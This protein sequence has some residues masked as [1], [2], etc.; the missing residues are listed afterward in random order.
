GWGV[1][2][3]KPRHMLRHGGEYVVSVAFRPDGK[4]LA[5]GGQATVRLWDVETGRQEKELAGH[6][7]DVHGLAYSPDGKW[8]AS[9]GQDRAVRL[10]DV[11][12][13]RPGQRFDELPTRGTGVA[14][15][16]DG[17][18]LSF[19]AGDAGDPNGYL[20]VW[21]I[22]EGK[23]VVSKDG[24]TASWVTFAPDSQSVWAGPWGTN[25]NAVL[26]RFDLAG[27]EL[28]R[29]AYPELAGFASFALTAD[30]TTL[31]VADQAKG[32]AA[33]D[34]VTGR[35]KGPPAPPA[36]SPDRPPKDAFPGELLV[37]ETFDD[38]KACPL[39][40]GTHDGVRYAV[41]NGVYAADGPMPAA[42]QFRQGR[43]G[44]PAADAAFVVR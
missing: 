1:E 5:S 22:A 20:R 43:L 28:A 32:V 31:Y 26:T 30:G 17:R 12:T 11:E 42:G 39:F 8:L 14:F 33:C 41:E 18:L 24:L 37:Y 21:S 38:P 2:S 35:P 13:G 6:T 9:G 23:M 3:G 27:R 44:G 36:W 25:G 40:Q 15:S 19:G 4:Q 29:I 10:W 34:P 7:G 16:P